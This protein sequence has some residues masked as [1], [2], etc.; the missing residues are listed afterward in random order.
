MAAFPSIGDQLERSSTLSRT[1]TMLRGRMDDM[2]GRRPAFWVTTWVSIRCP[3]CLHLTQAD[4]DTLR[5]PSSPTG[6][7]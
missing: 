7:A 6:L 3:F 5:A 4:R 2:A 1:A